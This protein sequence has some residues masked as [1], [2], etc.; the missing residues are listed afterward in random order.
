MLVD[1]TNILL[2]KFG[3]LLLTEPDGVPFQ[4][5]FDAR[6]IVF[7][8]IEDEFGTWRQFVAHGRFSVWTR[9]GLFEQGGLEGLFRRFSSQLG[10]GTGGAGFR[11]ERFQPLDNSALLGQWRERET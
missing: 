4:P 7:G 8:L 6:S 3:H 11:A 1:R 2:E 5:H 10:V 9:F